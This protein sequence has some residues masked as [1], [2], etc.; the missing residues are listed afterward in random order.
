MSKTLVNN[1]PKLMYTVCRTHADVKK[2][3]H[4]FNK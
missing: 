4:L 2:N 3:I 1:M